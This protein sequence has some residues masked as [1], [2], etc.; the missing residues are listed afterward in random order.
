MALGGR[1]LLKRC[2]ASAAY[3]LGA[4]LG[5]C[6]LATLGGAVGALMPSGVSMSVAVLAAVYSLV[7]HGRDRLVFRGSRSGW[8]ADRRLATE[9]AFGRLYFGG[10]LGFGIATYMTTPLVYALAAYAAAVRLPV[11][12]LA[13]VGF[14]LGRSRPVLTGLR[15][16]GRLSPAAVADRFGHLTPSDRVFGA[17]IAAAII[18]SLLLG[19]A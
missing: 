17:A 4:V 18:A 9:T 10:I 1:D 3:S 6:C 16:R 19:V 5:G 11:A 7:W 2:R 14:G 8:Q 13:G 15:A 12:L